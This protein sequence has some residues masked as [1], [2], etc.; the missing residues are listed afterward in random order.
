MARKETPAPASKAVA[1]NEAVVIE[2]TAAASQLAVAT[3]AQTERVTALAKQLNYNGSTDPAVLENSAL[4]A[5]RR[6]SM[7][8]FELGAY[9]LL[10]RETCPHG[11]FLPV[12]ERI[13][14][15][16][17][18]AQ[19][20]MSITR[21]F[22]NTK[23][24]S[25]LEAAGVT[26]LVELIALDNEQLDELTELG[27]T[28]ELALDDVANMS[29]KELRAAV[30][31]ERRDLAKQ[32]SKA[33]RLE[34]VNAELHDEVLQISRMPPDEGLKRIQQEA[35]AIQAETLG[36]VSGIYRRALIA[37]NN[38]NVDQSILMAGMVGQLMAE[39]TAL[40]DEF[41]LAEVGGTPDWERWAASQDSVSTGADQAN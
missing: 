24:T 11:Q 2:N 4:D 33:D 35:A 3:Q 12:L 19:N 36:M 26:K 37:L 6:I 34:A 23:S 25:H 8:V 21:R 18:A 40:R 30:R 39:L 7:T 32:K 14:L 1:I 9:L 20:Y 38:C 15:A 16:P 5:M 31:K 28:G 10:L 29:V 13:N 17:R 41:N 22:A 27:Q